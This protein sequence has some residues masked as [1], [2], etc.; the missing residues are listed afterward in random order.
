MTCGGY[1][2]RNTMAAPTFWGPKFLVNTTTLDHQQ[3]VKFHAL[4]NGTFVAV[5]EDMSATGGD[6]DHGAIRGQIFNVDG[7]KR[8]GEILI[9]RTARWL[10]DRS[11]SHRAE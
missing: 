9:N 6:T 10:P 5:W 11:G 4:K 2:K 1:G 8:G 7:T 3:D